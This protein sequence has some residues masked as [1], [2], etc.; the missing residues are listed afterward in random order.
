MSQSI[1][2]MLMPMHM[3]EAEDHARRQRNKQHLAFLRYQIKEKETRKHSQNLQD[4]QVKD[5]HDLSA[6]RLSR[7]TLHDADQAEKGQAMG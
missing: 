1:I 2:L 6:V 5:V 7:E 4:E 3:Q